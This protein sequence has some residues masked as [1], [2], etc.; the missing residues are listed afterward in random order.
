MA[1]DDIQEIQRVQDEED[2]EED[3]EE[4]YIRWSNLIFL[5]FHPVFKCIVVTLVIIK[6]ILVEYLAVM[7]LNPFYAI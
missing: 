1:D 7:T 5:P 3:L 6:T 4:T 2:E